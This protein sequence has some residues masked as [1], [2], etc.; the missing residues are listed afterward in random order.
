MARLTSSLT[1]LC[2]SLVLAACGGDGAARQAPGAPPVEVALPLVE[3][4]AD[5]DA[6]TGRFDSPQHV[7]VRS[8]VS[9]YLDAVNFEDGA[10]VEAGDL[11]FTIDPRPFEAG[12]A[13]GN[14]HT[15]QALSPI[16]ILRSRLSSRCRSCCSAH[17]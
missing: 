2:L 6:F 7:D 12:L 10:I 16:H 14:G 5:W 8:R 3:R 13:S 9:G 15:S 4:V 11:L 17:S 1:I